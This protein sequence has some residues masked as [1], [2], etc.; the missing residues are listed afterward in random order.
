MFLSIL[1]KAYVAETSSVLCLL[2]FC[3]DE[4]M[5]T[6]FD[7]W[8][9]HVCVFLYGGT[10][11]SDFIYSCAIFKN[12]LSFFAAMVVV[13]VDLTPPTRLQL[14]LLLLV[15]STG[16]LYTQ[17]ELNLKLRNGKVSN[18]LYISCVILSV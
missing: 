5:N 10:L 15:V 2:T 16:Q 12:F 8:F 6:T 1:K 17:G 14:K 11:L 4:A 7:I 18:L 3:Y 13:A 9:S